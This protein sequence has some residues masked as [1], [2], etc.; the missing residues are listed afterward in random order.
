MTDMKRREFFKFIS[1]PALFLPFIKLF[2]SRFKKSK[3]MSL[4]VDKTKVAESTD[5]PIKTPFDSVVA[6]CPNCG[7]TLEIL[8]VKGSETYH[9]VQT[10]PCSRCGGNIKFDA[11]IKTGGLKA[12]YHPAG[13]TYSQ[14]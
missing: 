10:Y 14:F 8:Y 13:L 3:T 4:Y 6:K 7:F 12:F 1:L 11:L 2:P 5:F 9:F